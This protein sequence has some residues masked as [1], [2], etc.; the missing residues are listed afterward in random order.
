MV[1]INLEFEINARQEEML[2]ECF[3]DLASLKA[4]VK[5]HIKQA[6]YEY[7]SNKALQE[8]SSTDPV[9]DDIN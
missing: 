7:A 9:F 8:L 5:K 3:G 1:M 4:A 6:L 2:R